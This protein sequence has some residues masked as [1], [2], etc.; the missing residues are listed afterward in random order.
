MEIEKI[1]SPIYD[2]I[3]DINAPWIGHIPFAFELVRKIR[4]KIFVELG[5]QKGYSYFAF[6]NAFAKYK[7][8]GNCYAVDT[9]EGDKHAGFYGPE[10]F[11]V[12]SKYNEKF[13]FSTLLKMEFDT[14]KSHFLDNEIDILHIDGLHTYEAV[15]HDFYNYLPKVKKDGII[16]LHDTQVTKDDFGVFKFWEELVEE[17]KHHTFEFT[18]SNGLGVLVL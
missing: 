5:T 4:P 9:W 8:E 16:L 2:W 18:Y 1:I 3:D 7:I 11:E 17:Y 6:C 15:K 14:A 13:T 12:V 10:V